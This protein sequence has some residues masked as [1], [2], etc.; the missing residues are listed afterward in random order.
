[1]RRLVLVALIALIGLAPLTA[2]AQTKAPAQTA[3]K[4]DYV[5]PLV[6]ATGALAGVVA[7]NLWTF[8][9]FTLPLAL[10]TPAAAAVSSPAAAAASRIYVI[11]AGVTG[12]LLASWVYGK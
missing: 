12:A 5:Y 4:T 10:D 1:M 2:S 11:T 8:P 7:V 3:A 6:L 9:Y